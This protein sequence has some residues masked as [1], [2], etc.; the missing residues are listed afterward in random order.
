[1]TKF[2]EF[3][4]FKVQKSSQFI[5]ILALTIRVTVL[6]QQICNFLHQLF[7][8]MIIQLVRIVSQPLSHGKCN[9]CCPIHPIQ[10]D[11]FHRIPTGIPF[12]WTSPQTLALTD[13]KQFV[14]KRSNLEIL[15]HK[16]YALDAS[17]TT[18]MSLP[19]ACEW[20]KNSGKTIVGVTSITMNCW[21]SVSDIVLSKR[22]SVIGRSVQLI[23]SK[24]SAA[25]KYYDLQKLLIFSAKIIFSAWAKYEFEL[26][27]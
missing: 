25:S 8:I 2:M 7:L 14:H 15:V 9:A 20:Q 27:C 11:I 3:V 24:Y 26:R 16:L 17:V 19:T 18:F 5:I 1:M 10:W 6:I 12:P 13:E 4:N 21:S 22:G 23:S